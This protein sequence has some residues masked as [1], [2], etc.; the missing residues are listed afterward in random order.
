[1]VEAKRIIDALAIGVTAIAGEHWMSTCLTSPATARKFFADSEEGRATVK[2][3]LNIAVIA[4]VVFGVIMSY[5][6]KDWLA[7]I[8][9][10]AISLVYYAIYLEAIGEIDLPFLELPTYNSTSE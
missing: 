8:T 5:I 7:I 9:A 10:V 6:L 2:Y 1:M 4:T 3:Y